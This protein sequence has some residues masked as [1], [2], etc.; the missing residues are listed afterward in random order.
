MSISFHKLVGAGNDFIFINE[1]QLSNIPDLSLFAAKIC[2]RNFGV[3]ADGLVVIKGVS[4]EG[5]HSHFSWEFFNNDGSFAEMCGNAAR[6]AVVYSKIVN[7]SETCIFETAIGIINGQVTPE[8]STV[9]WE[10]SNPVLEKKSITLD[11]NKSFDG[12]YIDTGVPHFVIL[13]EPQGSTNGRDCLNIQTHPEF[14]K[15]NT[16]VTL[17]TR[18]SSQAHPTKSFERGVRE[19]TLACG[20]GVIAASA[21]LKELTGENQHSLQAPGGKLS[22]EF[23]DEKTVSL[24]G[25][26]ELTFIG[27]F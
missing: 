10:I 6:C 21:V 8:G 26:A 18:K 22:V 25:P 7:G 16:N 23:H 15:R 17:L 13:D 12:W 20:T 3:G 1:N 5:N 14:G 19:F 24:T 11:Y 4:T 2:N 9:T 27:T